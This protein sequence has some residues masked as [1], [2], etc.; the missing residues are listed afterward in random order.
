MKDLLSKRN[1][2]IL[3]HGLSP[4]DEKTYLDLKKEVYQAVVARLPSL[5]GL[6]QDSTFRTLTQA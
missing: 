1:T 5:D 3:A 2:S 4:I 6:I